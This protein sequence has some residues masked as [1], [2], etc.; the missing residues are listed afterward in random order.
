MSEQLTLPCV[1]T[2]V[3]KLKN[4]TIREQLLRSETEVSNH[5]ATLERAKTFIPAHWLDMTNDELH[6]NYGITLYF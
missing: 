3:E 5:L 1:S 6:K 2:G 4:P